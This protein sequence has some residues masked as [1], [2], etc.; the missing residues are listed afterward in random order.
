MVLP[1]S[2]AQ[3]SLQIFYTAMI[4]LLRH[5]V[6][7][8]SRIASC[9]TSACLDGVLCTLTPFGY[10]ARTKGFDVP[11]LK[12]RERVATVVS[13]TQKEGRAVLGVL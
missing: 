9:S 6:L 13:K 10:V 12:H 11:R 2:T 4:P 7:S 1:T 8:Q 3:T 5:S